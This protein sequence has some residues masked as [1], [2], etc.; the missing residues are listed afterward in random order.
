MLVLLR[1]LSLLEDRPW[2][3]T[4]SSAITYSYFCLRKAQWILQ[5]N[6]MHSHD[7]STIV[8]TRKISTSNV[9]DRLKTHAQ[10][11]SGAATSVHPRD[12]SCSPP[13]KV[14]RCEIQARGDSAEYNRGHMPP[15]SPKPAPKETLQLG[16]TVESVQR[17]GTLLRDGSIPEVQCEYRVLDVVC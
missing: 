5:R 3:S 6:F 14:Q 10:L 2:N 17:V 1:V 11:F 15:H 12:S 8:Q 7:S 9:E 16:Q 4:L 13:K